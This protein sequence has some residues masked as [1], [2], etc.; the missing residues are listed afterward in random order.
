MVTGSCLC[1]AV[2]F[3]VSGELGP[4][5]SCHC[6]Q[7][8]KSSGHYWSATEVASV[9]LNI[10]RNHG[11]KWYQSSDH[12]RRGFCTECGSSLFWEV[13]G[14]DITSVGSGVLDAPTGIR[15]SKHIFVKY[16]GDYY[17]I[18]GDLPQAE[19]N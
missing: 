3:E 13:E 14:E 15:E 2:T 19:K 4:S 17:D 6:G 11:L 1:R 9:N 10:T 5:V 7:C 16:K 12:V 8:R 18:G